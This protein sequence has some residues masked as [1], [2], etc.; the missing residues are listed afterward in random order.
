MHTHTRAGTAQC[1]AAT[2]SRRPSPV[3]YHTCTGAVN[4]RQLRRGLLLGSAAANVADSTQT[5]WAAA[6]A[7]PGTLLS[8]E[9]TAKPAVQKQAHSEHGRRPANCR[10]PLRRATAVCSRQSH[11]VLLPSTRPCGVGRTGA[12]PAAAQAC[13][14]C[15]RAGVPAAGAAVLSRSVAGTAAARPCCW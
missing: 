12:A 10:H 6:G 3:A 4:S 11:R 14:C 13:C 8:P 15:P 1:V 5:N 2:H 9:R 7:V